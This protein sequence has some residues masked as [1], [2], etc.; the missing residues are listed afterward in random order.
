MKKG[1]IFNI[2]R[3]ATEDGP[4]IRT[5]VFL[6]GCG[7]RCKWCANP[8]SQSF[9]KEVLFNSRRCIG[10]ERCIKV[11][12]ENAIRYIEEYGYI[13]NPDLCIHCEKCIDNCYTNART[14]MGKEYTTEELI[15][16][17]LRDKE[18]YHMS[19]G[20]ITFS[21][22]EPLFYSSF[23]RECAEILKEHN[24]TTLIETCGHIDIDNIKEVQ[25]YSDYIF[26]DIKHMDSKIHKKLTGRG[27]ELILS[28]LTWLSQNYKGNLSVRY[29][30]I[31]GCNDDIESIDDFLNFVEGL[32]NI[33][34][35]V[36]LPY[37]R[38]GLPKYS[39]LGRKYEMGDMESLK[40]KQLEHLKVLFDDYNINI[41][42]Q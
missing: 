11:C 13:T 21:G 25:E 20:G 23:I 16:E 12:G 18:Y 19:G 31:P 34:E 42:I 33:Q 37:H 35:V 29:P 26:Y 40:K 7:L 38:L 8:E 1:R 41:K 10:C 24:I 36:F 15:E 3:F 28:N 14:M 9:E 5:V 39:G 30:Y 17:L 4:G 6:K 32:E 22:G 2:E 27:N